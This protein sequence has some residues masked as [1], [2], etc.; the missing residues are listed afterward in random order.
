M[1]C[2]GELEIWANGKY[3][4]TGLPMSREESTNLRGSLQALA[5]EHSPAAVIE[6]MR[7]SLSSS[8]G[9]EYPV[10]PLSLIFPDNVNPAVYGL[11]MYDRLRRS[12]VTLNRHFDP[13]DGIREISKMRTFDAAGIAAC[14][15]VN[16][17]DNVVDFFEPDAEVVTYDDMAECADKARWPLEMR[18]NARQLPQP[19]NAEP[20]A[21]IRSSGAAKSST[22]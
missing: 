16:G 6:V 4:P 8:F 18:T 2:G 22:N 14:M 3:D 13:D 20:G 7:D 5:K 21:I 1:C 10:L 11:E 19:A 9:T 15:P 12:R 17:A